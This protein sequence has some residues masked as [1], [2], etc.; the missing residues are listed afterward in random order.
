MDSAGASRFLAVADRNSIAELTL[1][2][3]ITV[4]VKAKLARD[5]QQVTGS[6][7][8]DVIGDRSRRFRQTDA[9]LLQ[10]LFD[11]SFG[12]G[13]LG[14][15]VAHRAVLY[16]ARRARKRRERCCGISP[17]CL[18]SLVSFAFLKCAISRQ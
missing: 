13:Y 17:G 16:E 12:H 9:K 8:R 2:H 5:G 14:K 4:A 10:F 3:Q 15:C 11:R 7:E 1:G 6:Y 18:S